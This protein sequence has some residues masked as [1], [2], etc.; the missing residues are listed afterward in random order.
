MLQSA[1]Q[2]FNGNRKQGVD[3]IERRKNVL[4][5]NAIAILRVRGNHCSSLKKAYQIKRLIK[6]RQIYWHA[7]ENYIESKTVLSKHADKNLAQANLDEFWDE[8]RVRNQ[9]NQSIFRDLDICDFMAEYY[10]YCI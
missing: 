10:D 2:L 5:I 6:Y 3:D 7:I 4:W 8:F 9:R 1:R